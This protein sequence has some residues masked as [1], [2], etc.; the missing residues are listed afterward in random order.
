[1]V[2]KVSSRF[3]KEYERCPANIKDKCDARIRL[4]VKNEFH[5]LLNN[6]GLSGSYSGHRSINVTGDW[7]AVYCRLN[8]D[9]Y[10]FVALGTHSQLYG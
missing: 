3:Q 7:R 1:M 4:F 6:H 5:P 2:I 9:T 8:K 10:L